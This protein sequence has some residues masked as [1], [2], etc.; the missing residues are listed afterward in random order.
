MKK[1]NILSA[2]VFYEA[3]KIPKLQKSFLQPF[4]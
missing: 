4:M 2:K 3:F 1:K